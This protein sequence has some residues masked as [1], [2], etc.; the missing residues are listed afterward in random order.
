MAQFN[1]KQKI[2]EAK[3]NVYM[4][5]II[6]ITNTDRLKT[7]KIYQ[8]VFILSLATYTSSLIF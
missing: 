2:Q 3:R 5:T 6:E 1:Q 7:G 8:Y 4:N